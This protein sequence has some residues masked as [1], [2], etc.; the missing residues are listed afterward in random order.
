MNG[1]AGRYD[2]VVYMDNTGRI[3]FGVNNG[4]NRTV[5]SLT[6]YRNNQW[7]LVTATL[8]A[9]GM[10][11][12]VD[13]VQVASSTSVTS[14]T[15]FKGDWQVGQ[16][17]LSGR[18]SAPT[19]S[20]LAGSVDEVAI[21]PTQLSASRISA[22]YA[23]RTGTGDTATAGRGVHLLGQQPGGLLRRPRIGRPRRFDHVVRVGLR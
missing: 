16:A 11:L 2:R 9:N 21:Y 13:G 22:H 10:R 12:Y 23:A 19:S 4:A 14:G 20:A 3:H 18:T 1:S 15:T 17:P 5:S 8:G 7:H 6:T